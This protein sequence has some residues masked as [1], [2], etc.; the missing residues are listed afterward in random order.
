MNEFHTL[1]IGKLALAFFIYHEIKSNCGDMGIVKLASRVK[2]VA[3]AYA[4]DLGC[5]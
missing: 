3:F 4:P 5:V 1:Y 2:A